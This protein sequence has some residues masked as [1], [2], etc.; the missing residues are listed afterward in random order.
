MSRILIVEDHR[1]IARGLADN[2]EPEGY[3][4]RIAG[5]GVDAIEVAWRGCPIWSSST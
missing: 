4:V 5:D 3:E 2:L 1:A